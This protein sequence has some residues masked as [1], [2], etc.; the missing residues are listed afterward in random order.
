MF[1]IKNYKNA[2][3]ILQIISSTYIVLLH[4]LST[5]VAYNT[6]RDEDKKKKEVCQNIRIAFKSSMK[7]KLF[8]HNNNT[9]SYIR[10]HVQ[11]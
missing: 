4:K 6:I 11:L 2:D 5:Y 8:A 7:R 1:Y 9:L 3:P 10:V